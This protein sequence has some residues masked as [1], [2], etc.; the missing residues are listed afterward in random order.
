MRSTASIFSMYKCIVVININ[1][2]NHAS[3]V[4][5]HVAW[6]VM[7]LTADTCLT[8]DL[9]VPSSIPA[10]SH[11]L[12]E[13]DHEIISMAILL[14]SPNSKRVVVNYKQKY[15]HKVLVKR[16]LIYSQACPGKKCGEVNLPSRHDHSCWLGC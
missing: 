1:P 8:E 3:G 13:I 15:V 16:L 12:V 10:W 4:P 5:G 11:S 14:P 9:R 2:A 7:C 6:L